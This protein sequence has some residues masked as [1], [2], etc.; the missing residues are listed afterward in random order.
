M[1]ARLTEGRMTTASVKRL[2]RAQAEGGKI[3]GEAEKIFSP[4]VLRMAVGV[5]LCARPTEGRTGGQL[6]RRRRLTVAATANR[7]EV[8]AATVRLNGVAAHSRHDRFSHCCAPPSFFSLFIRRARK[9]ISIH[10]PIPPSKISFLICPK[11]ET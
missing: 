2:R 3:F 11:A 6:R 5:K 10:P 7:R 4:A 9:R 8:G 1:G